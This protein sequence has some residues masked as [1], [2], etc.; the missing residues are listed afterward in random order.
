MRSSRAPW[1][2]AAAFAT[3]AT[4][5]YGAI[6][7]YGDDARDPNIASFMSVVMVLLV[8]VALVMTMLKRSAESRLPV[9]LSVLALVAGVTGIIGTALSG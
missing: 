2:I 3:M 9:K 4:Y 5:V 1:I 8:V 7:A 6:I